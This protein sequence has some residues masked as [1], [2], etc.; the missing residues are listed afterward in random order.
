MPELNPGAVLQALREAAGLTQAAAYRRRAPRLP[1]PRRQDDPWVGLMPKSREGENGYPYF[2]GAGLNRIEPNPGAANPR[3]RA[4][5]AISGAEWRRIQSS[6]L[7]RDPRNPD[8][9]NWDAVHELGGDYAGTSLF[10]NVGLDAFTSR[11]DPYNTAV[12]SSAYRSMGPGHRQ[13]TFQVPGPEGTKFWNNQIEEWLPVTR[14][15][16]EALYNMPGRQTSRSSRPS[17]VM[18]DYV[19]RALVEQLRKF[20]FIRNAIDRGEAV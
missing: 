10:R 18:E 13:P 9:P 1:W 3:S 11:V 19:H 6:E 17:S 14:Q 12:A 5:G 7:P 8:H 4:E 15:R 16:K 20:P 2:V